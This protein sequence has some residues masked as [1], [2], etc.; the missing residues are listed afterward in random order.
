MN[1]IICHVLCS[2]IVARGR[3]C[4]FAFIS[5]NAESSRRTK[6]ADGESLEQYKN[7]N[8]TLLLQVGVHFLSAG[9]HLYA[10]PFLTN[11]SLLLIF[12]S[13]VSL[14]LVMSLPS[15][16]FCGSY[17][18]VEAL[19]AQME[20]QTRLAKDQI[21]SLME[22]RR[23]KTE[24]AQAQ[25]HRDQERIT[26]L[27]DKWVSIFSCSLLLYGLTCTFNTPFHVGHL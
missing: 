10:L 2:L 7:D 4:H 20:E 18:Q 14:I 3:L 6:S 16:Y 8:Q 26:A 21:E 11:P 17:F 27:T 25:Q 15:F 23:I 1:R 5:D 12:P 9:N 13:S 22:D 19:Q 24:E